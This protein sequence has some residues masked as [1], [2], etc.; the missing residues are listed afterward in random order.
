[1]GTRHI[2]LGS[3]ENAGMAEGERLWFAPRCGKVPARGVSM[4]KAGSSWVLGEEV[5]SGAAM[6][7]VSPGPPRLLSP[8][9]ELPPRRAKMQFCT[10]TRGRSGSLQD[11]TNLPRAGRVTM[12][13]FTPHFNKHPY[14]S[15][16]ARSA[17]C[18]GG[19]HQDSSG[20]S[21]GRDGDQTAKALEFG[22]LSDL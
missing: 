14:D 5:A 2:L 18:T 20:G 15:G 1:M 7:R 6:G 19:Q 22:L 4:T 12:S 8:V 10:F 16:G 3:G 11:S 13:L 9:T 21:P 17:I